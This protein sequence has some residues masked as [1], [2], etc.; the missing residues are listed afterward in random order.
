MILPQMGDGRIAFANL[1]EFWRVLGLLHG[2]WS[3]NEAKMA[4]PQEEL[5]EALKDLKL[6]FAT[7]EQWAGLVRLYQKLN[8]R[9]RQ[10]E[11]QRRRAPPPSP[12][13]KAPPPPRSPAKPPPRLVPLPRPHDQPHGLPRPGP[14]RIPKSVSSKKPRLPSKFGEPLGSGSETN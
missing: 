8:S 6:T 7:P 12:T 11:S 9:I 4:A 2:L 10:R 14:H 5:A 3:S 1:R 13:F